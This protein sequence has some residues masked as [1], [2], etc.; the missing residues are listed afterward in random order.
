MTNQFRSTPKRAQRDR[1]VDAILSRED[2]EDAVA[3]VN[4]T[5]ADI[6]KQTGIN[7][8]YLSEFKSGDR[9]LRTEM[10]QT[11][12]NF[13][14]TKGVEFVALDDSD[15]EDDWIDTA[16]TRK[17]ST[18]SAVFP[19]PSI[20]VGIADDLDADTL[21][22]A[23]SELDATVREN[24]RQLA[25]AISYGKDLFFK[26]EVKEESTAI[27]EELR[28]GLAYEAVL[29]RVLAGSFKARYDAGQAATQADLIARQ[30]LGRLPVADAAGPE[31]LT[32]SSDEDSVADSA[33][34]GSAR[35]KGPSPAK[36]KATVF[37]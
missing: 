19:A 37:G 30:L 12:R 26:V 9:N 32:D 1:L 34:A 31:P 2:F 3:A 6:A 11:L 5:L 8:Q 16:P 18:L 36:S 22:A 17:A 27:N 20:E 29:R 33:S 13:F 21:T 35:G 25:L 28:Q 23:R 15:I 10:R 4:M 7:R 14:E 24:D